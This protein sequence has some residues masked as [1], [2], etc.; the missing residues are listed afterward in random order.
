VLTSQ[1]DQRDSNSHLPGSGTAAM[2]GGRGV[3]P[4]TP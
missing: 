2:S 4:L 3:L 1:W